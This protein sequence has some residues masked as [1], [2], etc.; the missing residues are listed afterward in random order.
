MDVNTESI[1]KKMENEKLSGDEEAQSSEVT[2]SRKRKKDEIEI[3]ETDSAAKKP[4]FPPVAIEEG[5]Y[6][7]SFLSRRCQ[8][9]ISIIELIELN[10]T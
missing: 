1:E 7:K 10:R 2:I 8:S 6:F 4:N 5:V 9:K 3:M